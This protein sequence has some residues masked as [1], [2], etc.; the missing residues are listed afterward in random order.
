MEFIVVSVRYQTLDDRPFLMTGADLK[1]YR[2]VGLKSMN[3][4]R[5]YFTSR[6]AAIISADTPGVRPANLLLY[7]YEQVSRPIYPLDRDLQWP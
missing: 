6:A 7:P 1:N 3:H 2:I 4:F 5:G